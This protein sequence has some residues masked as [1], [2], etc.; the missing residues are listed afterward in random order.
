[1]P[2]VNKA[3]P[4]WELFQLRWVVPRPR[5][6]EVAEMRKDVGVLLRLSSSSVGVFASM[7]LFST[8]RFASSIV[9]VV[10]ST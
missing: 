10:D 5:D 1:M 3:F 2:M 4:R 9:E 6:C 7:N 8:M